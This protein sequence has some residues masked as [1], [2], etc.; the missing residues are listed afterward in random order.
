MS[1]IFITGL[2]LKKF[3]EVY[4]LDARIQKMPYRH[5]A[6]HL[7]KT[8]L[9]CR[10][11]HHHLSHGSRR[12]KT[13]SSSPSIPS[14][15]SSPSQSRQTQSSFRQQS[16]MGLQNQSSSQIFSTSQNVQLPSASILISC[17]DVLTTPGNFNHQA[18]LRSC[19]NNSTTGDREVNRYNNFD[20]D[21]QSSKT[22]ASYVNSERLSQIY[23]KHRTPFWNTIALD[24]G[25][26]ISPHI[27]EKAW[28]QGCHISS[29]PTPC[30]SPDSSPY[31][32][33]ISQSSQ[34]YSEQSLP[35]HVPENRGSVSISDL[36][37]VVS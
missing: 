17:S 21:M 26:G 18:Y 33:G 34:I 10:L 23:E 3:Q 37:G 35:L 11:H 4:L 9:A 14:M 7:K 24:Y 6:A 13:C 16:Y 31:H 19:Q 36:L 28:K 25:M 2:I 15:P 1:S 22:R 30:V 32:S 29:L 27:L 5:I 12:K 8:E 20:N